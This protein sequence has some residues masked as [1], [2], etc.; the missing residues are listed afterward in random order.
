MLYPQPVLVLHVFYLLIGCMKAEAT[1]QLV[2]TFDEIKML[3]AK[4]V[5]KVQQDLVNHVFS[6]MSNDHTEERVVELKAKSKKK[7]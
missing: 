7:K 5:S 3:S 4:S 1:F 2:E 6:K